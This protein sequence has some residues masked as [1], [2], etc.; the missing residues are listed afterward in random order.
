MSNDGAGTSLH[1]A[2]V[3]SAKE[4]EKEREVREAEET[5]PLRSR[6][7]NS[8][9]EAKREMER[10]RAEIEAT[11]GV[12][13]RRVA[14]EVAEAR[15]QLDLPGRL[16]DA[17]RT[18]PLRMLAIA[19]GLGLGLALVT[20]AGKRGYD[21]LTK[22]EIEE[23][24]AWRRERRRYLKRLEVLLEQSAAAAARPSLRQRIRARLQARHD[25]E[26]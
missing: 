3:P 24:R 8:P 23:I 14:G 5:K 16:R 17:V 15:R 13:K 12:M 21:T 2:E 18:E 25:D 11:V 7:T 19:A 6:R 22:D 9:S 1:P 26:E 20:A 4:L 10:A